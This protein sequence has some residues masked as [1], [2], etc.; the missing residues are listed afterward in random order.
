MSETNNQL[1][2][3]G[4]ALARSLQPMK[5]SHLQRSCAHFLAIP[6]FRWTGMNLPIKPSSP[7]CL[8]RHA[9]V[10][11]NPAKRLY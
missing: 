8:K 2:N 11:K 3:L 9:F 5:I 7:N 6:S 10:L 1:E 4:D